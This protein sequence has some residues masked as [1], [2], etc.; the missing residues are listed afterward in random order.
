MFDRARSGQTVYFTMVSAL[1]GNPVAGIASGNISG[2]R[3]I[4]GGAQTVCSGPVIDD[5]GGQYH[6]NGFALDFDGNNI[7]FYFTASGCVPVSLMGITQ[8]NVSGK[9]YPASGAYIASGINTT[10]PT[11]SISGTV[12]ASGGNVTVP[13][14]SISGVVPVSGATVTVPIASISGT[15][16]ASGG[17]VIVP[18]A[19]ISGVQIASG[20]STIGTL[21]SGTVSTN[22]YASGVLSYTIPRNTLLFDYTNL[23]GNVASGISGR[24]LLNATRKLMNKFS[25]TDV[26]GYLSV[27]Q[28]DDALLAFQQGSTALSGAAPVTALDT[29]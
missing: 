5:G 3:C 22:T 9:L 12:F 21:F 20:S 29:R 13:I 7:G 15:V 1:S 28:E 17:N 10:V 8:Q 14:S 2:R 18:I 19:S 27:Y 16:F 25:F 6:L 11:S 23:S 26:S 24:C 4:D